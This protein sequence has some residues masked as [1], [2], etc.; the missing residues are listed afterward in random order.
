MPVDDVGY[1]V[2][3]PDQS[4]AVDDARA[5]SRSKGTGCGVSRTFLQHPAM[6]EARN[7][8]PR[9]VLDPERSRLTPHDRE[10]LIL[11]MGWN[12]GAVY[13]WAKHG[14]QRRPGPRP[15]A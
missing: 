11:R 7:L 8:N 15:T 12:S 6:V 1:R 3:V 10:L 14:R 4:A 13:E 5:S 2:V 9:Y